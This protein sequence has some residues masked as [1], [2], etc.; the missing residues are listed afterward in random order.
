MSLQ[1]ILGDVSCTMTLVFAVV[2]LER[3]LISIS[4][5]ENTCIT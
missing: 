5:S 3:P 4:L 1:L 2:I